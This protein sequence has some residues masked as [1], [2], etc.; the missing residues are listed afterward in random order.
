MFKHPQTKKEA[1]KDVLHGVELVDNYRWLEDNDSDEVKA[2]DKAQNDFTK[3]YTSELPQNKWLYNKLNEN[4][5]YDRVSSIRTL[6]ESGRIFQSQKKKDEEKWVLYTAES[7]DAEM[8]ILLNPNDW[9][10]D[11]TLSY[12]VPT[13]DGAMLAYGVAKGGNEAPVIKIMDIA[14]GNHHDDTVKGWKQFITS[15]LPDNSGF[16]YVTNP[17]KGEVQQEKNSIGEKHIFI[18]SVL[19]ALKILKY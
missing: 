1:V 4:A 8:R 3:E 7:K 14:T 9:A 2:W 5:K 13:Q 16:Y 10:E 18:S 15:W 19:I 12:W 17:L 11:E 6:R